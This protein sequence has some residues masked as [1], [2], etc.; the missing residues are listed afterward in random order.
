MI[1]ILPSIVIANYKHFTRFITVTLIRWGPYIYL[2]QDDAHNLLLW[3]LESCCLWVLR[4]K[5]SGLLCC[6]HAVTHANLAFCARTSIG[7]HA[8]PFSLS[9]SPA[10]FSPNFFWCAQALS[11]CAPLQELKLLIWLLFISVSK[12]SAQ[13]P[14]R[15]RSKTLY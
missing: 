15:L 3:P 6:L 13:E 8:W 2:W 1:F 10:I 5:L 14:P 11:V 7:M 12:Q 9:I 4:V